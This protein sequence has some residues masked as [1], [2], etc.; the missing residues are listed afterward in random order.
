VLDRHA[1]PFHDLDVVVARCVAAAPQY[2]LEFLP[3][4]GG[5]A[6]HSNSSNNSNNSKSCRSR[7][8]WF[9]V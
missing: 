3:L 1:P 2:G 4:P 5:V 7:R 8:S 6:S 9:D